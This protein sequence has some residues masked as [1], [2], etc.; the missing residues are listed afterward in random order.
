MAKIVALGTHH[1]PE[2]YL[3][4]DIIRSQRTAELARNIETVERQFTA[5]KK[6]IDGRCE[7]AADRFGD[8]EFLKAEDKRRIL[9]RW[10]RFVKSGFER[11]LFTDTVY[12]HLSPHCGYI[13]HY[14]RDGFYGEYWCKD[15]AQHA[16]TFGMVSGPVPESFHNWESFLKAFSILGDYTDINTDM[17]YVL[18]NELR[19]LQ[20]QLEREAISIYQWEATRSFELCLKAKKRLAVTI[21]AKRQ[22]IIDLAAKRDDM[23]EQGF[24]DDLTKKFKETFYL[25]GER[26]TIAKEI[27]QGV[28]F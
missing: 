21:E 18:G 26:L 22:E 10:Q 5:I 13:A 23:D 12:K 4:K 25:L 19:A 28:L 8:T 24:L 20:E 6:I 15:V 9:A 27:L 7:V 3:D 17:M 16:A 14:N 1:Y 11:D 2:D